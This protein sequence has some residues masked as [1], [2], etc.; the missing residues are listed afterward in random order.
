MSLVFLLARGPISLCPSETFIFCFNIAVVVVVVAT[1]NSVV[2]GP[3]NEKRLLGME[4]PPRTD[5]AAPRLETGRKLTNRL[6]GIKKMLR[7][8]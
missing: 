3:R 2:D 6:E 1:E 5:V 8:E 7:A 4:R